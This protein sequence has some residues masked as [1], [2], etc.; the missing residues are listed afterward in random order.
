MRNVSLRDDIDPTT[1]H[2]LSKVFK[3][4]VLRLAPV[5]IVIVIVLLFYLA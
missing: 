2:M 1:D 5:P 3:N 4:I